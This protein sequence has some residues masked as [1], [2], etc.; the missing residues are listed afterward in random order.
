MRKTHMR[1]N[2][3]AK[4]S[5]LPGT[6]PGA[7]EK[8]IRNHHIERRILL[9]QGPNRGS[10][11]N[12]FDTQQLHPI[13]VCAKRKLGR[14][15]AMPSA[16]ARKKSHT[17]VL[18]SSEDEGVRRISERSINFDFLDVCQLGHLIEPTAADDPNFCCHHFFRTVSCNFV[19]RFLTWLQTI[20]KRTRKTH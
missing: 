6:R 14:C 7:V 8:L 15:K 20:H 19:D 12:T 5:R 16:V 13:D 17:L 4:K 3:L 9:L 10:R 2:S 1:D 18:Q 11:Q